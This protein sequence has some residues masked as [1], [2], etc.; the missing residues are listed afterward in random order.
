LAGASCSAGLGAGACGGAA[1]CR[2]A[3][4]GWRWTRRRGAGFCCSGA[5]TVTW[6]SVV[7]P[8]AVSIEVKIANADPFI[9]IPRITLLVFPIF[10]LILRLAL[11]WFHEARTLSVQATQ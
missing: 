11:S 5:V 2:G 7:W 4:A 10:L 8:K 1:A 6:G 9:S 3:C